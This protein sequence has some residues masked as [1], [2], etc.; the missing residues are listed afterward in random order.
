[1]EQCIFCKIANNEIDSPRIYESENF[2]VIKDLHPKSV[3]HLLI[4]PHNHYS[5]LNDIDTNQGLAD[6]MIKVAQE[7]AKLLEIPEYKFQIN[8]GKSGG[9]EVFHLHAHF[10][11]TSRLKSIA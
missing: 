1:M 3:T 5:T 11:S 8:V 2:F 10:L 7:L 9:Q 4:I 6:E